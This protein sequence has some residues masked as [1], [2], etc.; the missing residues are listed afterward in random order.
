MKNITVDISMSRNKGF[1]LLEIMLVISIFVAVMIG[2]LP[3]SSNWYSTVSQT[4]TTGKLRMA[5][6]TAKAVA[7]KNKFSKSLDVSAAAMCLSD[8]SIEVREATD[9]DAASCETGGIVWSSSIGQTTKVEIFNRSK[10]TWS[11][12]QCICFLPSGRSA[13]TDECPTCS[14]M[15]E[16]RLVTGERNAELKIL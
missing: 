14:L 1:T 5:A 11:E 2:G 16:V 4:D 6:A 8:L 10:A 12:F 15:S 13:G 9:T 7:Q 3:L